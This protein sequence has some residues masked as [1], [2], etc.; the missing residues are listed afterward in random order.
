MP[1]K[2]VKVCPRCHGPA[3]NN[4]DGLCDRCFKAVQAR[5][6]E[7]KTQN[8]AVRERRQCK[9]CGTTFLITE[10]EAEWY[11]NR[12]L[13]LPKRC[14]DCRRKRR[15]ASLLRTETIETGPQE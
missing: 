12:G 15:E 2:N 8:A 1:D 6:A 3:G 11:E 14:P 7:R 4:R 9:E 13:E 5:E 10:T